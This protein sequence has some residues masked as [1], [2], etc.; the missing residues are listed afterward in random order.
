MLHKL[1]ALSKTIQLD[2]LNTCVK[3]DCMFEMLASILW[4]A[5]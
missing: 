3:T 2:I 1:S 5:E 4:Q